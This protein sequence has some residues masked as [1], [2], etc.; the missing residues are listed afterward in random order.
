MKCHEV[1]DRASALI[2]GELPW[3]QA[4]RLRMHLFVCEACARFV[5]QL[6]VTRDLTEAAAPQGGDDAAALDAIL[7]RAAEGD[8][9]QP[10]R[11]AVKS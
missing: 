4:L 8:G 11:G 5:G 3:W 7:R 6:R 1:S 2:D 10:P 9:P